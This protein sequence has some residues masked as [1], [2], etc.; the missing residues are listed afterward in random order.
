MQFDELLAHPTF[1]EQIWFDEKIRDRDLPEPVKLH[2]PHLISGTVALADI[3]EQTR[4]YHY[5][6]AKM[7]Q[8]FIYFLAMKKITNLKLFQCFLHLLQ[9]FDLDPN[10]KIVSLSAM[11]KLEHLITTDFL[12]FFI[13]LKCLFRLRNFW[14]L[15][16]GDF[17]V[18][19]KFQNELMKSSVLPN[20]NEKLSG[21]QEFW[22]FFVHV[23]E[24][25]MTS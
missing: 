25:T 17:L 16:L 7:W 5:T 1:W 18:V 21:F 8:M 23:L 2:Q 12:W 3:T 20:M 14:E 6:G 13:P 19:Y 10:F 11:E 22:Q 15:G 24:E 9:M 4:V